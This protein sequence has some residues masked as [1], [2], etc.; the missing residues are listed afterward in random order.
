MAKTSANSPIR[1]VA[2]YYPNTN[3]VGTDGDVFVPSKYQY[4]LQDV[5][6]PDAG[7]SEDALMH[8]QRISQKVKIELE[9]T[10]LT[11]QEVS[12]L[13][14]QFNPEYLSVEYIDPINGVA[15]DGYYVRKIFYVGD[16]TS[17]M[18]N[19]SLGLWEKLA[20]NIIE[21]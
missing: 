3:T 8:K 12:I 20:F 5:S 6:A 11:T 4:D 10:G 13:L 7:R 16:R 19:A 2:P 9:W 18:Y 21:R 14:A 17:P 1:K 15:R